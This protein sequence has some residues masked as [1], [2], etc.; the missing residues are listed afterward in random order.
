M[1]A[2]ALEAIR[3]TAQA[4][5]KP[6]MAKLAAPLMKNGGIMFAMSYHGAAKVDGSINIVA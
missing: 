1:R 4:T 2:Q 3:R 5:G 6:C